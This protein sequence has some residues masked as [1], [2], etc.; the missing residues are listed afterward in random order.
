MEVIGI[1]INPMGG[2]RFLSHSSNFVTLAPPPSKFHR[3]SSIQFKFRNH[4]VRSHYCVTLRDKPPS[5]EEIASEEAFE[6]ESF[7]EEEDYEDDSSSFL[8]LSEKPDRNL[9]L[10]DE[11][12]IEENDFDSNHRSG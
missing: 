2:D 11:Y 3:F 8:S 1:C 10:L 12:E 5:I 4:R 7:E 6:E 9:A